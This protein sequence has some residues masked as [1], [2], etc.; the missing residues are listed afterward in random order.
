MID[1]KKIRDAVIKAVESTELS[2]KNVSTSCEYTRFKGFEVVE[3]GFSDWGTSY[4]YRI[5][6]DATCSRTII[7]KDKDLTSTAIGIET[8]LDE[9]KEKFKE[10]GVTYEYIA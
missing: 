7:Y 2:D 3:I 5:E 6:S 8:V 10:R 1:V 9:I 4:Y